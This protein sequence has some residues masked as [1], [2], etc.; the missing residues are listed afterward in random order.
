MSTMTAGMRQALNHRTT[1]TRDEV[2]TFSGQIKRE[3]DKAILFTVT[4]E[5][6][7]ECGDPCTKQKDVWF[8]LSQVKSIHHT[9]SVVNDTLDS[10]VVTL[11]IAKQKELA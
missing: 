7:D 9:F 3:S 8:P 6:V 5:G 11:W 4:L 10:I 1:V 2:R